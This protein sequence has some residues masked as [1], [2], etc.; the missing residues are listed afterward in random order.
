MSG[1]SRFLRSGGAEVLQNAAMYATP[2]R[3]DA[4]HSSGGPVVFRPQWTADGRTIVAAW[5][6]SDGGIENIAALPF[7]RPGVTRFIAL[8][9]ENDASLTYP[10]ALTN[11]QL[12]LSA[13]S[14]ALISIDLL[15]GQLTTHPMPKEVHLLPDPTSDR[16]GYIAEHNAEDNTS[17]FGL[18]EP[19]SLTL[20]PLMT[21]KTGS[22]FIPIA[23]CPG[24]LRVAFIE[25]SSTLVVVDRGREQL[26]KDLKKSNEDLGIGNLIFSPKGDMLY[27]S[28]QM[29]ADGSDHVS[30][31]FLEIPVPGGEV[32]RMTL[33]PE[34]P[35]PANDQLIYYFQVSVSHDGQTLAAASTYLAGKGDD[36]RQLMPQDCALFL[37]DLKKPQRNVIRIPI[38]LP[39][40]PNAKSIK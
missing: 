2:F 7:G 22:D 8:N 24:E 37:V 35:K 16:L 6:N 40:W 5:G 14:D 28:F 3:K 38:P 11:D 25:K 31:G 13:K 29:K 20:K 17:E 15:T 4:K 12:F 19:R 39:A 18:F 26:R 27:A 30:Y 10:L 1:L 33:I 32:R 36:G 23:I 21:F 9:D 34:A